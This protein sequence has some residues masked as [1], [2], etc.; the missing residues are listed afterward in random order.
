M[1]IDHK[2]T[3][4]NNCMPDSADEHQNA[5][6]ESPHGEDPSHFVNWPWPTA[7][8]A[9]VLYPMP[10]DGFDGPVRHF[11]FLSPTTFGLA[12]LERSEYSIEGLWVISTDPDGNGEMVSIRIEEIS[13]WPTGT[14]N[15]QMTVLRSPENRLLGICKDHIFDIQKTATDWN[16]SGRYKGLSESES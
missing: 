3:S 4:G 8:V 16:G 1:Q 11:I 7:M 2:E 5:D 13:R 6:N 9:Q 14:A 15:E 12:A 10:A